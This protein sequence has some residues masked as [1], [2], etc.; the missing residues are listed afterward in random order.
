MKQQQQWLLFL[1]YPYSAGVLAC[2]WVGSAAMIFIDRS[3]PVLLIITIN[4]ITSW[5]ITWL[6]FQSTPIK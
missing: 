4:V 3:M 5:L 2:I 6:G 1:K